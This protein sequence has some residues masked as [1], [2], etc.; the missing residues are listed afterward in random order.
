MAPRRNNCHARLLFAS[1]VTCWLAALCF[2]LD[3]YPGAP[4]GPDWRLMRDPTLLLMV[5]LFL[6]LPTGIF[7]LFAV[8]PLLL[9]VIPV[10]QRIE[11][12]APA[13]YNWMVWFSAGGLVGPPALFV[14]SFPL[15]LGHRLI[16]NLALTGCMCG[17]LCAILVRWL[18]GPD[19][20]DAGTG[21]DTKT[22]NDIT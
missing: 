7:A 8:W 13:R 19:V 16:G 21:L 9:M 18:I 10:V 4:F 5:S 2:T 3:C 20:D 11:R 15:G 17:V 14:Y 6:I 22:T 12:H 1:M